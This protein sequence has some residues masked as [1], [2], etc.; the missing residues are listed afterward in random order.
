MQKEKKALQHGLKPADE[1]LP[2]RDA[3]RL[4]PPSTFQALTGVEASRVTSEEHWTTRSTGPASH[5]A[6]SYELNASTDSDSD[7]Y[8]DD[9]SSG[10]HPPRCRP[11]AHES[12]CERAEPSF[13]SPAAPDDASRRNAV[14]CSC[15][16]HVSVYTQQMSP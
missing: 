13:P 15:S 10:D 12:R 11:R 2:T 9:D 5:G 8:S 7:A 16:I 3:R 4:L 1:A 6:G 14:V